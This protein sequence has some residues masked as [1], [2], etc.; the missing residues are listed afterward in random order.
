[1]AKIRYTGRGRYARWASY[2]SKDMV[3]SLILV[4]P[5]INLHRTCV[6]L[7]ILLVQLGSREHYRSRTTKCQAPPCRVPKLTVHSAGISAYYASFHHLVYH[8][9]CFLC[10]NCPCLCFVDTVRTQTHSHL[11]S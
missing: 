5:P 9:S 2:E 6:L 1:M 11:S 8:L 7:H 3:F 10:T 4:A